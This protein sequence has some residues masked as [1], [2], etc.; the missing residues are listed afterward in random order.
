[1]SNYDIKDKHARF[2]L[3]IMYVL[4]IFISS[5]IL[6]ADH[7]M[8]KATESTDTKIRGFHPHCGLY[9]LYA[10]MKMNG[11]DINFIDMVKP[12]YIGS[13]KGSSIAELIKASEKYGLYFFP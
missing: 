3:L 13:R 5:R 11:R 6:A 1:M 9:C 2:F 7:S 8:Q 12:E 4:S 10:A